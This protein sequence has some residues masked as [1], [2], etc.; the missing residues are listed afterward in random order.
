MS[1]TSVVFSDSDVAFLWEE[2]TEHFMSINDIIVKVY[3]TNKL[4]FSLKIHFALLIIDIKR[5][6]ASHFKELLLL[7]LKKIPILD[8]H[9]YKKYF[10]LLL[11]IR[12]EIS[13]LIDFKRTC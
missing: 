3:F 11:L 1:Y 12:L 5:I 8:K 4:F 10:F 9:E 13:Y 2:D 6:T 7:T